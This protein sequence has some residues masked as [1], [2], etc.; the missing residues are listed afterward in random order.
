MLVKKRSIKRQRTFPR[1]VRSNAIALFV[2]KI[3]RNTEL[4]DTHAKLIHCVEHPSHMA[5]SDAVISHQGV[6]SNRQV[7]DSD[8]ME[9]ALS[10]FESDYFKSSQSPCDLPFRCVVCRTIIYTECR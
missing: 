4:V 5:I 6:Q 7:I 1:S 9:I 10:A 3:P 8:R 2:A